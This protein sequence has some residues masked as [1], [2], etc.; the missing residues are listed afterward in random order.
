MTGN[1]KLTLFGDEELVKKFNN[2]TFVRTEITEATQKSNVLVHGRASSYPQQVPGTSY[3]RT[4]RLGNSWGMS[5]QPLG[6]VVHGFVRNPVDY[7]KWVI[8][9]FFQAWM[10]KKRWATTK[11]ILREKRQQIVRFYEV[12]RDNILRKFRG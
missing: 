3:K 2:T 8:D 9:T 7:G 6:G 12:A 1:I 10:H 5:V 4:R 11:Q